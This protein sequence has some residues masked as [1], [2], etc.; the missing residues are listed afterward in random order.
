[1]KKKFSTLIVII[2][3]VLVG[4]FTIAC[5]AYQFI[6]RESI[7]PSLIQWFYT[8]FGIEM[9]SLAGIKWAKISNGSTVSCITPTEETVTGTE[10]E[11]NG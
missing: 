3:Y 4:L 6:A 9:L 1:M 7:E 8:F 5:L 11:N 2:S 10:G